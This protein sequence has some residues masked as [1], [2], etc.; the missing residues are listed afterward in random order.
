MNN[1]ILLIM[2]QHASLEYS[3]HLSPTLAIN[4]SVKR[5]RD[6]GR[7]IFHMGFGEAP[8]PAPQRMINALQAHA[9]RK[10]YLPVMGLPELIEA[11]ADHQNQHAGVD[12]DQ[13][14]VVIGPGSK[15][16]LFAM[17]M[18]IPGDLLLPTPSWVSYRPQADLL[19]Q[20]VIEVGTIL[21]DEGYKFDGQ[22]LLESIVTSRSQGLNPTK[23]LVNFPNNPSGLSISNDDLLDVAQICRDNGIVIISDEIYGRLSFDHT[24]RSLAALYPE[25]TLVTSG[26]SK[27]LSL[28]G[29]RLG[30]GMIPKNKSGL[31]NRFNHI[32]SELWSSV[33]APIQYAAIE[34]Y[35]GHDDI[36]R[37]I[38]DTT[39][40]HATV[41]QYIAHELR[42]IGADCAIPQGGFYNWPDF[43]KLLSKR[44]GSSEDLSFHLL[45]EHGVATL[46]GSAFG[47][48]A[49][50]L[51][52]R[53][54][55]CDY[56]GGQ[57]L[58]Q[59]E[60]HKG[61]GSVS[62]MVNQI[63]PNVVGALNEFRKLTESING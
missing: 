17:Q 52:L 51:R 11:V 55:G 8:F 5:I 4:E 16:I 26:L 40:I 53:L 18:A 29:W 30:I 13:Y 46:P 3:Q 12:T 56:D 1:P 47:E 42:A 60:T 44:F 38:V 7:R 63:A 10:S 27:H 31:L 24:Y 19:Q 41:N 22:S 28:G 32:A 57:A 6:E 58:Q 59:W 37:F 49:S 35:Q 45:N 43:S 21:S 36:E 62:D 34:A 50:T 15:L 39:D 20:R 33:P 14:D 23:L 48:P 54:S 61:Q 25:G 9:D 2:K